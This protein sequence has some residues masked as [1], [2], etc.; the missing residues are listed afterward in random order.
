MSRPHDRDRPETVGQMRARYVAALQAVYDGDAVEAGTQL[1]PSGLPQHR[2]LSTDG[3]FLIIS[4][5]RLDGRLG[6][7]I[8]ASVKEG[9]GLYRTIQAGRMSRS[10]FLR[11]AIARWAAIAG[12]SVR[13]PRLVGISPDKGVPHWFLE[14]VN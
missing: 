3:L 14:D 11:A 9:T 4:R 1:A 2:F 13:Q 6:V 10:D 8:S 5:D 7:H 12:E